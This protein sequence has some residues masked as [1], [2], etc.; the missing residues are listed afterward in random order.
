MDNNN[1]KQQKSAYILEKLLI[2]IFVSGFHCPSPAPHQNQIVW[3]LQ[4]CGGGRWCCRQSDDFSVCLL[5]PKEDNHGVGQ[6]DLDS[7]DDLANHD[8]ILAYFSGQFMV[9]K[10]G[11]YIIFSKKNGIYYQYLFQYF[12]V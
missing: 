9:C 1:K 12:S 7:D 4:P 8:V 10:V 3:I 11:K 5:F 2:K 6:N